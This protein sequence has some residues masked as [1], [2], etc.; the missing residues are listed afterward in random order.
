MR[1]LFIDT[2][3]NLII[4]ILDNNKEIYCF[5]SHEI[6]ETS[7]KVMPIL[8]EAF[9]KTKLNIKDI[10]KIFVVNGPGSF[11][12]IRVGVTIAK[13]IG[14]CLNIPIIPLSELELLATTNTNTNYNVSL[15]D[16]RRGYV[17]GAIYDKNLN[18]YFNEQHILLSD[19]EK[20]YPLNHTVITDNDKI[21]IIKIIKKHEFDTPINPHILK[22]NYLKKTE[23]EENLDA[24]RNQ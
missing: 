15:I 2:S 11:T 17:Y 21:D 18:P 24:K 14:F 12:G 16:A 5:N 7:A 1:Y 4:S 10:D 6:H 22:P 20:E 23:A 19:L 9:T 8:D 3:N 13:I